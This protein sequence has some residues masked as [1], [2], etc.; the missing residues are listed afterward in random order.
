METL[1][2]GDR[3]L[4]T[5]DK[6]APPAILLLKTLVPLPIPNFTNEVNVGYTP[7]LVMAYPK[8]HTLTITE[9]VEPSNGG[10]THCHTA[11]RDVDDFTAAEVHSVLPICT[12]DDP[13]TNA[14]E[15]LTLVVTTVDA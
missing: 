6:G 4:P 13:R 3:P 7:L 15:V 11:E 10:T 2:S 8:G 5:T 9:Y 1:A 12:V 14:L